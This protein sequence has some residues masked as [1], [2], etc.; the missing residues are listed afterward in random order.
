MEELSLDLWTKYNS[1]LAQWEIHQPLAALTPTHLC[2]RWL[3]IR[4]YGLHFIRLDL[5]MDRNRHN[6]RYFCKYR[7]WLFLYLQ[8]IACSSLK[9]LSTLPF[10]YSSQ[11]LVS[12]FNHKQT[13]LLTISTAILGFICENSHVLVY[14]R[15]LMHKLT[16]YSCIVIQIPFCSLKQSLSRW[17]CLWKYL[18]GITDNTIGQILRTPQTCIYPDHELVNNLHFVD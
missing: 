17:W 6:L 3:K 5:I 7:N 1:P 11:W 14:C 13:C 4:S 12:I 2:E 9:F 8:I 16:G 15:A 18:D 10:E